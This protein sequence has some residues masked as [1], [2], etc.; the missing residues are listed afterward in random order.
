MQSSANGFKVDTEN[1]T[2]ES[3][4]IIIAT[5]HKDNIE[6]IGIE[7]LQAVYGKSVYPCPFCDA[8][9]LADK[10]LAV[11][12]DAMMAPMFAKTIS[13][14]SKDVIV[15]TN[16]DKVLDEALVTN[17]NRNGIIIIEGKIKKINSHNGQLKSIELNDGSLFERQGGFLPDTKSTEYTDFAK[18][19][20]ISIELDFMGM[21]T[22]K[23][24]ENRETNIEGLYII[25]DA[26]TG[27]SGVS[28]C[29]AEG[30]EVAGAI[31]H[32]IIEE[33]WKN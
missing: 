31:T 5:G 16:G 1:A 17:L 15:F 22:Y 7:G 30:S 8:F 2:Y 13:H 3:K 24:N 32:Q 9:E 27:W 26:R 10:K 25:G 19:M 11:I 29:V 33:N 18:N 28:S 20:D 6:E 4:R 23:V 21:E 14:W 12:G